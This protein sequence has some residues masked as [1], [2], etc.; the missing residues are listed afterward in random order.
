MHYCCEEVTSGRTAPDAYE[1]R[2]VHAHL[3]QCRICLSCGSVA[4]KNPNT[5]CYLRSWTTLW[6][7]WQIVSTYLW[8][9]SERTTKLCVR[10]SFPQPPPKAT[11]NL[12]MRATHISHSQGRAQ[13]IHPHHRRVPHLAVRYQA[14]PAM[15]CTPRTLPLHRYPS[16]KGHQ[17]HF[18][19][20][21]TTR[22]IRRR[23]PEC[24]FRYFHASA[25][26]PRPHTRR[27]ATAA[28]C[29]ASL[30]LATAWQC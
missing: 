30:T 28:Q 2:S 9:S 16:W 23:S 29:S 5:G 18:L 1:A 22:P 25:A 26:M 24:P 12:H 10:M 8:S 3:A 27:R 15:R 17:P 20:F 6:K 7:N 19:R 21:S 14:S 11:L 4:L 13:N